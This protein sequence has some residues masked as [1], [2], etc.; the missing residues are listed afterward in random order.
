MQKSDIVL[1]PFPFT[2]LTGSKKRPALILIAG[3][4]DI[5]VSFI[6]TQLHW[7]EPTDLLL[8]SNSTNG[9]KKPSLVR[10]GK[11]AT[12]DKTLVIGKL[13]NI[14]NKEVEELDKKLVQIFD[15]GTELKNTSP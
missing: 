6:S 4:L 11:M 14:S 12:I 2:D 15:I 10:V 13:G 8:Q 3:K 9:L 7:Q 1:I 5:T